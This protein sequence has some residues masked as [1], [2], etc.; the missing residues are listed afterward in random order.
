MCFVGK[1]NNYG[2]DSL[3]LALGLPVGVVDLPQ[4]HPRLVVSG[5][6]MKKRTHADVSVL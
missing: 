2:E 5:I 1:K 3:R 6:L 4:D